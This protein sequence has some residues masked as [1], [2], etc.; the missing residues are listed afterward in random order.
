MSVRKKADHT[1][2]T[3]PVYTGTTSSTTTYCSKPCTNWNPSRRDKLEIQVKCGGGTGGS[4]GSIN[5]SC[6]RR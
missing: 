2:C 6:D 4:D 5:P 1:T 3:A